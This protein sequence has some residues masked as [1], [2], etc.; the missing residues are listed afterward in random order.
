MYKYPL[1]SKHKSLIQSW[2]SNKDK[3]LLILGQS[4]SGKTSLATHLLSKYH[5]IHINSDHIKHAGN[6]TDYIK[7]SLYKKD[8]LM[9]CSRY[10]YKCLLVDD[11]HLF[12]NHDK[13]T[14]LKII[15]FIKVIHKNHPI[16]VVSDN[17]TH[18]I[19]SNL[20]SISYVIELSFTMK[21]Y[22]NILQN[23]SI[24]NPQLINI[25]EQSDKNLH[26]LKIN[27]TNQHVD[28]IDKKY[29][30]NDLLSRVL[31]DKIII[32]DLFRLF[33]SEYNTISLNM[34]ENSPH[35]IKTNMIDTL[36]RLYSSI[37]MNDTIET[38]YI[39]KDIDTDIII[40]FSC[41]LPRHHIYN[42]IS[43][44]KHY[45]FKYNSYISRSLI[46]IHNQSLMSSFDYIQL[47]DLIYHNQFKDNSTK[48]KEKMSFLGFDRK[49]LDRQIKV[50]NY[51]YNK[52][53]SK[54]LLNKL[55]K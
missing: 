52:S 42:N 11:L 34:L 21:F 28:L 1:S 54:R 22:M 18:K 36:Y 40:L 39:D 6:I 45:T 47:L 48:I 15:Q 32:S 13:A 14:L 25:I 55:L 51:Y 7:N 53:I 44:P 31:T 27:I 49:V 23:K 50:Y 43:L 8:I 30:V 38:K 19:L 4:G 29:T 12:I 17:L 41:I 20:I 9:M 10:H 26:Q 33:S 16:I 37:C 24:N 3:P 35:I 2:S 46:Q 5:I